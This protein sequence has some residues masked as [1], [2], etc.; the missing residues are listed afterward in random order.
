M[1]HSR[2]V[3]AGTQGTA[4]IAFTD[5]WGGFSMSPFS[6]LNLAAHVDDLD[7]A[8]RANRAGAASALGL[9][10]DRLSFTSQ[11]HGTDVHV[12]GTSDGPA[13]ASTQADAQVTTAASLGL[14]VLVAD[15]TPVILTDP[16]AGIVAVAHAG[17]RGMAEGIIERTVAAMAECGAEQIGAHIGPSICPRCYEVPAPMREEIARA[18]PVAASTSRSGTPAI[19]VAGGVAEQLHR[20]GARIVHWSSAC[21]FET[22]DLFSY[23]R[24]GTTGRFAGIVWFETGR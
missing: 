8:V 19:D 3:A 13:P 11:V 12:I 16:N 14:V 9:R 20:A 7:D 23:R 10:P 21:T 5:R 17:R 18:E 6:S 15:C 4:H 22:S 24:E 2:F 1:L